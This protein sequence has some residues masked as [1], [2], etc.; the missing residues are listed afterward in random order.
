M[1]T[2]RTP[3]LKLWQVR[4]ES[5][6]QKCG[7]SQGRLHVRR[8]KAKRKSRLHAVEHQGPILTL[9]N[10]MEAIGLRA[11]AGWHKSYQWMFPFR[12]LESICS[13]NV[14][15]L[16]RRNCGSGWRNWIQER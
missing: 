14:G 3:F 11:E 8:H 16:W 1:G 15:N 12:I 13:D 5:D 4:S 7:T 2:V 10:G 9:A 6:S